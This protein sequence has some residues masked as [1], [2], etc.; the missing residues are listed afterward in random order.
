MD[1]S[2]IQKSMNQ[3]QNSEYKMAELMGRIVSGRPG[4][5]AVIERSRPPKKCSQCSKILEGNE[6]FCPECGNKCN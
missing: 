3:M 5:K 4:Y 1:P 6:K 2:S